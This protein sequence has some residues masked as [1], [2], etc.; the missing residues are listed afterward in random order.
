MTLPSN[1]FQIYSVS[2][3]V[4]TDLRTVRL[5]IAFGDLNAETCDLSQAAVSPPSFFTSLID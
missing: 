3:F 1:P 5:A 4:R 2:D